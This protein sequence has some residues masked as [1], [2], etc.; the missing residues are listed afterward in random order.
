MGASAQAPLQEAATAAHAAAAQEGA[1]DISGTRHGVSDGDR[2][3]DNRLVRRDTSSPKAEA[4]RHVTSPDEFDRQM[5]PPAEF[6]RVWDTGWQRE[7]RKKSPR[8]RTGC[9]P[10]GQGKSVRGGQEKGMSAGRED[11]A[12]HSAASVSE[13]R[14]LSA[15]SEEAMED[16]RCLEPTAAE[17]LM[18]PP[19]EFD[20]VWG[21][22]WEQQ[23]KGKKSTGRRPSVPSSGAEDDGHGAQNTNAAGEKVVG[24]PVDEEG[25]RLLV[26]GEALV[27]DERPERTNAEKLVTPPDGFDSTWQKDWLRQT[28]SRSS[29]DRRR[30]SPFSQGKRVLEGRETERQA[31]GE[32]FVWS[33]ASEN[34]ERPREATRDGLEEEGAT[35][36]ENNVRDEA[37]EVFIKF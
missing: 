21:K 19:E 1:A 4:D 23:Y 20:K 36:C 28:A 31:R 37:I 33:P 17:E 10:R 26:A 12:A 32:H 14:P 5:T 18:T 3:D 13:G 16:E 34:G 35:G 22:S 29:R 8:G 27:H 15:T 7:R 30:V 11:S 6:D 2:S 24:S 25:N 9:E